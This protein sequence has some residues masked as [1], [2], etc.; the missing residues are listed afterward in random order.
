MA[1][2]VLIEA[3]LIMRTPRFR[4]KRYQSASSG[5]AKRRPKAA[6]VGVVDPVAYLQGFTGLL[7]D[8]ERGYRVVYFPRSK[9]IFIAQTAI[10][11]KHHPELYEDGVP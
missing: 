10:T 4:M 1:I 9:S 5:Y 6:E 3:T 11:R 7:S 2:V 8:V